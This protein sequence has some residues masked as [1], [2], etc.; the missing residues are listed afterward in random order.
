MDFTKF[1]E[2]MDETVYRYGASRFTKADVFRNASGAL[3]DWMQIF[4]NEEPRCFFGNPIPEGIA[5]DIGAHQLP[6][7]LLRRFT[8]AGY[9]GV[10][11]QI[12][13]TI[14]ITVPFGTS[15][16]SVAPVID[17]IGDVTPASGVAQNFSSPVNYVVKLGEDTRTYVVTVTV[18]AGQSAAIASFEVG[19]VAGVIDNEAGT[20]ALAVPFITNTAGVTPVISVPLGATYEPAGPVTFEDGVPLTFVVT[21]AAGV[22]QAYRVT[23]TRLPARIVGLD[24]SQYFPGSSGLVFATTT[25]LGAAVLPSTVKVLDE[26]GNS[27]DADVTWANATYSAF[28]TLTVA[29]AASVPGGANTLNFNAIVEVVDPGTVVWIDNGTAATGSQLYR[30]VSELLGD[31][32]INK[33]SDQ[34]GSPD[35]GNPA[36]ATWGHKFGEG[37]AT[38]ARNRRVA[39]RPASFTAAKIDTGYF[40]GNQASNNATGNTNTANNN[41][42]YRLPLLPAG[43]YRIDIH[44]G[45]WWSTA[46][47][48]IRYNLISGAGIIGSGAT[49]LWETTGNA[50]TTGGL[51]VT[52]NGSFTLTEPTML[53]VR[54]TATGA[55]DPTLCWIQVRRTGNVTVSF[56]WDHEDAPE[57]PAPFTHAFGQAILETVF[58]SL[59]VAAHERSDYSFGGWKLP[60]G[61]PVTPLTSFSGD[62]VLTPIWVPKIADR[63]MFLDALMAFNALRVTRYT[64]QSWASAVLA[65]N[66][67][68]ALHDNP[69]STIPQARTAIAVLEAAIAALVRDNSAGIRGDTE[70]FL[71]EMPAEFFVWLDANDLKRINH[72]EIGFTVSGDLVLDDPA[73][74][75][76]LGAAADF[77]VLSLPGANGVADWTPILEDGKIVAYSG[78]LR[79]GLLNNGLANFDE[80]ADI[81]KLSFNATG[82]GAGT[83]A[84]TSMRLA[85]HPEGI[86]TPEWIEV[87][88]IFSDPVKTDFFSRFDLTRN[89]VVDGLDLSIALLAIGW[90]N[91]MEGWDSWQIS[92]D[93]DGRA[94]TPAR[95]DVNRDGKIDMLDVIEILRHYG[96]T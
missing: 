2:R 80:L 35:T 75:A 64:A 34:Q 15:V 79:L 54:L 73:G 46:T 14:S 56:D 16:T 72:I 49:S 82:F 52:V 31:Q 42:E 89:G 84:L 3:Y 92:L 4:G 59:P 1:G 41:F 38:A 23:T 83:V 96:D 63:A 10:I 17:A 28:T 86:A 71:E 12:A 40:G 61:A 60:N 39:L 13:G 19:G 67:I 55:Q 91:T 9:E 7:P 43:T 30:A 18:D 37:N 85:A 47:R 33:A 87:F 6:R 90:D 22:V 66:V 58:N 20:I 36:T 62:T 51:G 45:E 21:S 26:A 69:E 95:I 78:M 57:A 44:S 88:G 24:P 77:Q 81:V 5:P 68:Q 74:V 93:V 70:R 50:G 27:L 94:I 29:G 25:Q 76:G 65:A 53:I 8:F 32:L 11:D 48:N